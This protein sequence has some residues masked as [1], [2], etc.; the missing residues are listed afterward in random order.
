MQSYAIY[1]RGL[2]IFML[3]AV[4]L[5]TGERSPFA[6]VLKKRVSPCSVPSLVLRMSIYDLKKDEAKEGGSQRQSGT[7]IVSG[8][9]GS[10]Q[11]Q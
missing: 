6:A 2:V 10:E 9:S 11:F 1:V 5:G 4:S 8:F 3:C 7:V